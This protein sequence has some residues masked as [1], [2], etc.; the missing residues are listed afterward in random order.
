MKKLFILLVSAVIFA[1][2]GVGSYSNQG[3]RPDESQISFSYSTDAKTMPITVTIDNGTTY[4]IEAVKTVNFKKNKKDLKK[5]AANTIT[6]T[7]G[8][9]EVKVTANGQEIYNKKLFLSTGENRAIAL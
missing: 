1:S 4:N 2:C 6:L 9:H 3:G 8:T 5:L 7:P